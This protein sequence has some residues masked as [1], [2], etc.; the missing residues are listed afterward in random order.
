MTS[1]KVDTARVKRLVE[2]L[3]S[4][5]KK[6]QQREEA[7]TALSKQIKKVK[8]YTIGQVKKE[9]AEREIAKLESTIQD[10]LH[11][12]ITLLR[13]QAENQRL[14]SQLN[15]K[16]KNLQLDLAKTREEDTS[17][18]VDLRNKL[19]EFNEKLAE[20]RHDEQEIKHDVDELI[21]AKDVRAK[22]IQEIEDHLRAGF[23]FNKEGILDIEQKLESM[24][25]KLLPLEAKY[26]K[27]A[28]SKVREKITT[29]KEKSKQVREQALQPKM[30]PEQELP[31]PRFEPEHELPAPEEM[32]PPPPPPP[33]E[34]LDLATFDEGVEFRAKGAKL[35]PLPELEIP[36]PPKKGFFQN[37]FGFLKKKKSKA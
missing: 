9:T 18:I 32:P 21:S 10:V 37:L 19:Q 33:P 6:L 30:R 20:S 13:G 22:K 36:K 15:D 7:R 5:S 24:D 28:V 11:K 2:H 27:E 34:K 23:K 29:L 16:I 17:V 12:E 26:G 3:V 35:E 14:F 1:E 4:A 25:K 8:R 31:A